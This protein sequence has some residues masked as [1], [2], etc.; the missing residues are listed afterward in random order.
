MSMS[1]MI[2]EQLHSFF[3]D[4]PQGEKVLAE[5]VWIGGAH[6]TGGF[7]I[8]CKT[9]TLNKA[10]E[11]VADLPIWNYDGSS[12]NQAPGDNSEVL[13]K[14]CSIFKDPFRGGQNILVMCETMTPAM[15]PLPTNT[16]N[17][18]NKIFEANKAEEPWFGIEQGVHPVREGQGDPSRLAQERFPRSPRSVLLLRRYRCVLRSYHR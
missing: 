4:L 16:R 15:E 1:N 10:P 5:Y 7:D 6:T 8:R 2:G 14:P 12:T 17:A 9:K 11:S 18:A 3:A 13:L